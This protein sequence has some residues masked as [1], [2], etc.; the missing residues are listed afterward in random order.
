MCFYVT[1]PWAAKT[2]SSTLKKILLKILT[3]W[4]SMC[5]FLTIILKF[6]IT[7]CNPINYKIVLKNPSWIRLFKEQTKNPLQ[8]VGDRVQFWIGKKDLRGFRNLKGVQD[9]RGFRNPKGE[10]DLR[11]LKNLKG[12]QDL[13]GFGNLKGHQ[14]IS[15]LRFTKAVKSLPVS[16]PWDSK[17]RSKACLARVTCASSESAFKILSTRGW[18]PLMATL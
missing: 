12:V 5:L 9:L 7:F 16:K 13:R 14:I 2:W 17:A 6:R 1:P 18:L 11:G 15:T 3:N 10:Q 8:F 4:F